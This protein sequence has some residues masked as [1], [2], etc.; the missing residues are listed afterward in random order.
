MTDDDVAFGAAMMLLRQHGDRAPLKVAGRIGEL[1][2]DGDQ[3]GVR[4]WRQIA[5]K[6]DQIL[7]RGPVQ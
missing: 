2:L 5:S 1:A 3:E 4:M 6:M 7:R